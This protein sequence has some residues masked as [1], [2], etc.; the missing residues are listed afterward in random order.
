MNPK[1]TNPQLTDADLDRALLADREAL[2]PSSGFATSVM[3]AI[4]R[5]A[6]QASPIRF[7]WKRALPGF[8]AAALALGLLVFAIVS[9]LRSPAPASSAS[10]AVDARAWL[11]PMLAH[12]GEVTWVVAA[13]AVP[14]LCLLFCR[15]LFSAR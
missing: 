15:R 2:L 14:F 10:L 12:S 11:A 1:Q 13:L 5:E 3:A 4:D 6:F 9:A 7:P 8:A